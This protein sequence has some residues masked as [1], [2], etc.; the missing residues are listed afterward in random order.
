MTGA[1]FQIIAR[2]WQLH[3]L[4][5]VLTIAGIS[6]GVAVFFAIRLTNQTLV[7]SLHTTIEKLAGRSTL[8]VVA[9]ESG[10]PMEI[11]DKVRTTSGVQ[12][13]EPVTEMVA[14]T[15]SG[16]KILILGLDTASDLAL[17]GST[18]DQNE[19]VVKNPLAFSNRKDSVAVT[20][21][22]AERLNLRDG[23]KLSINVQSGPVELTVR[24]IFAE[25]GIGEVYDGNVAVMDIFSARELFGRGTNIDRIDVSNVPAVSVDELQQNLAAW[26]PSGITAIRPNLRGQS[27]ENAV[28]SMNYGLTIMSFLAL[29][30]GI[31][32]IF[33]SFSISLNQRW[34]QIG[35]LRAVGVTRS[36]VRRMFL[37]E[38]AVMGLVGSAVGV[39]VGYALAGISMRFVGGVT[40]SF[41]GFISS[42][43][44]VG[45]N[46][47]FALQALIAG[48]VTSLIAA[49]LPARTASNLDPVLALHNIESRQREAVMGMPRLVVGITLVIAGVLFTRFGSAGVGL[50]YQL[51]YSFAMQAGMILLVPK[52]IQIGAIVIRPVMDKFFGSE[53]LL[54][55]ETMARSPRRTT[56][57]VIALLIGL[58]FAFS[59]GSFIKSQKTALD[60][61]LNRAADADMLVAASNEVHSRTYHFS[62]AMAASIAAIPDVARVDPVRISSIDYKGFEVSML[63]HDMDAYFDISPD[64]LDSGDPTE[65]RRRTASGEGILV[66]NNFA[67]RWNAALGDTVTLDTPTGPLSLEIVGMLDYY[68][69]EKGTIFFDRT[70]YKKHWN[71]SNADY[72]F[73]DARDGADRAALK[74]NIENVVRSQ[75]KAFIYTH[76]EYKAWVSVIVDQFFSLMYVQMVVAVFVAALGLINTMFISV[77]ERRRELGIFRAIGGLRRQVAK[78]VVLE[79]VA[80]SLI[81]LVTGLISGL[82]NAYFLVNT[83]ARIIAG[84]SL[85]LIFPMSMVLAAIPIVVLVA[86]ISA[87]FPARSAARLNIV[88]AIGYE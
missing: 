28:S 3:K 25:T 74:A 87:W 61:T 29:T 33:N 39:G 88:E 58:S 45:F 78:M 65:A 42:P 77:A 49:W 68:R 60:R 9:G 23:S 32:I 48:I 1:L 17:Y 38:A 51:F 24:G 46:S 15:P 70:L 76:E 47:A 31:F 20:R 59:H 6:L 5:L 72:V 13:A 14:T 52:F 44:E 37:A 86:I 27:L 63:T 21:S 53:G 71:D 35:I 30:I 36:N 82:L 11:I 26:L 18:I 55:V 56:S 43:Q 54:A 10:F 19:F 16:Q 34:K 8:Q 64:L 22:L 73:V 84:F 62:E 41:Y 85:P 40:A 69:S 75:Q 57:T 79:A 4:R 2:D 67:A 66:S 12:F 50:N 81:G 83:A 80:I 7:A